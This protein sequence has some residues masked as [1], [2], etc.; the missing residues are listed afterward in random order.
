MATA[1]HRVFLSCLLAL[2]SLSPSEAG[3]VLSPAQRYARKVNQQRSLHG[4]RQRQLKNDGNDNK[5]DNNDKINNNDKNNGDK[6]NNGKDNK[7]N[8]KKDEVAQPLATPEL[9]TTAP[10]T[11]GPTRTPPDWTTAKP[12]WTRLPTA[13][14][15]TARP[16]L[17]PSTPPESPDMWTTPGQ[18]FVSTSNNEI[19]LTTNELKD[20]QYFG[21]GEITLRFSLWFQDQTAASKMGSGVTLLAVLHSLQELLCR[22]D[23]ASSSEQQGDP[24]GLASMNWADASQIEERELCVVPIELGGAAS[25]SNNRQV[26]E[27][28]ILLQPPTTYVVDRT[29]SSTDLHWTTWRV[30]WDVLRLGTFYI[31]QGLENAGE[32][33]RT[34]STEEIYRA[35]INA[36][37]GILELALQVSIRETT[38][39]KVLV[40][41]MV[42]TAQSEGLVLASVYGE[43][44]ETLDP[45]LQ[46]L[47]L[48]SGGNGQANNQDN[49]VLPTSVTNAEGGGGGEEG[50][51]TTS[52]AKTAA[53]DDAWDDD[54]YSKTYGITE[55]LDPE[56]WHP[57]RIVGILMFILTTASLVLLT[58]MSKKRRARRDIER[59]TAKE[60]L[61]KN[62][63]S[64]EAMLQASTRDDTSPKEEE[65]GNDRAIPLPND[66]QLS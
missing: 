39:D 8:D 63:Q 28:S 58:C 4:A 22:S 42:Q 35:G 56:F 15:T 38:L 2:L 33:A 66:L 1:Q 60:G 16:T 50:T 3:K 37:Q 53:N 57:L 61:L 13:R 52:D 27:G 6:N 44:V 46:W 17:P 18:N 20:I 21:G 23:P 32:N 10:P 45:K 40:G 5:N 30:S 9:V 62:P 43:E 29:A 36:L 41:A 31:L 65:E 7:N 26:T 48:S 59:K 24:L 49:L 34:M 25:S 54:R 12:T 47:G 14:P 11:R 19:T 64:L 51:S 55:A